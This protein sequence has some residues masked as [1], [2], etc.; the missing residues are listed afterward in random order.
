VEH[1]YA[2]GHRK[3]V[4]LAGPEGYPNTNRVAGLHATCKRLGLEP[5]KLGPFPARFSSGVR[6]A[7]L[8]LA[9]GATGIIAYNDDIAAGLLNRFA[10]YG[11]RVPGDVSVVGHDDT[12]LAEIVTP[13]LTTVRVPAAAAAA[14]A[15]KL[16]IDRIQSDNGTTRSLELSSELIV[17]ASTGPGPAGSGARTSS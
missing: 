13:R 1:L 8:V 4:Y 15:T 3:L 11:V 10:D 12:A 7:D 2:L 6:A 16:L 17:R 14:A 5:T 9:A